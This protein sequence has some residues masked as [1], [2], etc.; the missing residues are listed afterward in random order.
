LPGGKQESDELPIST[1]IREIKEETGLDIKEAK[2]LGMHEMIMPHGSAHLQS[3]RAHVEGTEKITLDPDEHD[4][5]KWVV[6]DK[7][8]NEDNVIWGLPTTLLDFGLIE[9]MIDDPTLSDG[10]RAVLLELAL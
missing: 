3:F 9:N 4:G 10:S 2:Y 7:I 6:L 8:L 1:V 5:F